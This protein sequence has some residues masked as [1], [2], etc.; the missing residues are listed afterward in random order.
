[1]ALLDEEEVVVVQA[2]IQ[3]HGANIEDQANDPMEE[4]N[5]VDN[6]IEEDRTNRL[7]HDTFNNVGMD[8]DGNQYVGGYDIAVLE[9]KISLFVKARKHLLSLLYF[10]CST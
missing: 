4:Y 6:T 8:D 3:E 7:I 10:F 9:R 5:D 2:H 1:M